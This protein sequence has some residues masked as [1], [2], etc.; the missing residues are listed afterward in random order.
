MMS[1]VMDNI[2][3]K[4][5]LYDFY[6]EILTERQKELLRQFDNVSNGKQYETRKN[7]LDKLKDVFNN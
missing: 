4:N 7:F 3:V 1:D 5:M 6:G 2:T